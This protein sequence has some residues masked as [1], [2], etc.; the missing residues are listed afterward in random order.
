MA[1]EKYSEVKKI[2]MKCFSQ[3]T[4]AN[5]A[6]IISAGIERGSFSIDNDFLRSVNAVS[7]VKL[8]F[9]NNSAA[10]ELQGLVK[11]TSIV[12]G[13][14][15]V[16]SNLQVLLPSFDNPYDFMQAVLSSSIGLWIFYLVIKEPGAENLIY[17]PE[18]PWRMLK[19]A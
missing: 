19:K 7:D 10:L 2:Q 15:L 16:A 18:T 9:R 13:I 12:L 3:S 4:S 6:A 1:R 5:I 11:G 14:Y 8:D 17:V